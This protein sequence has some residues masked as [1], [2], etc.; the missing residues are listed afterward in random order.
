MQWS[1]QVFLTIEKIRSQGALEWGIVSIPFMTRELGILGGQLCPAVINPFIYWQ[2]QVSTLQL[3]ELL[4][5]N[6]PVSI[7]H[8]HWKPI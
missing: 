6:I 8:Q 1:V 7:P 3:G 4:K 5:D 2:I